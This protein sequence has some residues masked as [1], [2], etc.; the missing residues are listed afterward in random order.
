[1]L[2]YKNILIKTL[3]Q[4]NKNEM[5]K[6]LI[7]EEMKERFEKMSLEEQEGIAKAILSNINPNI[8][9]ELKGL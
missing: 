6:N 9:L 2:K 8:R 5:E 7:L 1:M 4:E 3:M